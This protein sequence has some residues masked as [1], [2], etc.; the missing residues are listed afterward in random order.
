MIKKSISVYPD[1]RP[2][3]EIAAYMQMAASYGFTNVFTS[4]FSAEGTKEEILEQFEK[5]ILEAHKAGLK[6]ALDVNPQLFEKVGASPE[7]IYVFSVIGADILRMDIAFREEQNLHLL[8]NPYDIQIMFN[9]SAATRPEQIQHLIDLGADPKRILVGHNFYP[10]R[11]TGMKW[12]KFLDLSRQFHETGA[13]VEAFIT[14]HNEPTHGVWDAKCGL[15]TVEKM[16]DLPMDLQYRE[17]A[18]TG[19]VDE[20]AIGNAYASEAELAELAEVSQEFEPDPQNPIIRTLLKMGAK[21]ESFHPQK[22][23]KVTLCPDTAPIEKEIL[24]S[25]FPHSDVGDSSEWIW[26][27]RMPR[28]FYRDQKIDVRPAEGEY[29]QPGSVLIVNDAYKHYAGEIQIALRPILNDGTRNLVGTICEEEM[30][31]LS[32]IRDLDTV[33]FLEKKNG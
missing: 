7:D 33:V 22:K 30:V 4:M 23:I 3:D 2:L 12:Q 14:S 26:R 5:F 18:A 15:C 28:F 17:L 32:L 19:V 13:S 6:V 16:R 25:F 29:F 24:F 21:I 11:Y 8:Q 31:M 1:L 10:Q 20:I 9:A 27:S